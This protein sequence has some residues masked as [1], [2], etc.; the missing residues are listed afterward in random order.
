M[1][2][3][4]NSLKGIRIQVKKKKD[5]LKVNRWIVVTLILLNF[6]IQQKNEVDFEDD[7]DDDD[8]SDDG[9]PGLD[10]GDVDLPDEEQVATNTLRAR[11]QRN[12]LAWHFQNNPNLAG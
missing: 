3:R 11:V 1:K 6:L 2:A 10:R 8:E 9:M 7:D 12:L 5:F 4:F